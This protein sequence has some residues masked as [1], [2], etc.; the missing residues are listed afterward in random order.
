MDQFNGGATT[1]DMH[2]YREQ[3]MLKQSENERTAQV[4]RNKA[5]RH[6]R[7]VVRKNNNPAN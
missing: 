2:K 7:R 6:Q 1:L 3:E 5:N 4:L